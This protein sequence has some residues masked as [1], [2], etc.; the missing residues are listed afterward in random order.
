M[1]TVGRHANAGDAHRKHHIP[2]ANTPP[3][4][5][6]HSAAIPGSAGCGAASIASTGAAAWHSISRSGISITCVCQ[7]LLAAGGSDR[8]RFSLAARRRSGV[9]LRLH[10]SRTA[11][12]QGPYTESCLCALIR[13]ADSATPPLAL[14]LRM[15]HDLKSVE[16]VR[17]N[18]NWSED[19]KMAEERRLSAE[20]QWRLD[21]IFGEWLA[22]FLDRGYYYPLASK[23]LPARP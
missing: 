17:Y 11:N 1:G 5:T 6:T 19:K 8:R 20:E 16:V 9:E 21:D 14:A 12:P 23:C 13:D 2:C 22:Y 18:G 3:L 7:R 15:Y 4:H 10:L